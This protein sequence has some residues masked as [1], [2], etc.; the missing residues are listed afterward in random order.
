[1][2]SRPGEAIYN[3]TNGMVEGNNTFQ[4]A[5]LPDDQRDH[6]LE[7]LELMRPATLSAPLVF[8]GNAPADVRLNPALTQAL[9]APTWPRAERTVLAWLGDPVAIREPVAAVFRPQSGSN[10]LVVGQDEI[11]ALGLLSSVLVSLAA[12][13]PPADRL[14]SPGRAVQFQVLDFSATDGTLAD[15]FARLAGAMGERARVV[16]RRQLSETLEDLAAVVQ[17]R[18]DAEQSGPPLFLLVNGLQ[19]ARDLRQEDAFAFNTF[20]EEAPATSPAQ[21]FTTILR[22]GPEAGIHTIVWCDSVANL[23]RSLDRRAQ[24]EFALRVGFQMSA[25]DS[26]NL[27]D[28]PAASRLGPHRALLLSEDEGRLDK[29]RPYGL[30]DSVWIDHVCSTLQQRTIANTTG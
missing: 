16:R 21:L 6:Y 11:A 4:V 22:D 12:T 24:R 25:E 19:R 5:W 13:I 14:S 15:H 18:L 30:P 29:F 7:S 27:L 2:L 10:L 8:E 3:A 28:S 23:T 20:G 9:A 1:L 26:A 17:A